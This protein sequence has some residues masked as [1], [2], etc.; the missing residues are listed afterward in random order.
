MQI[1]GKIN[2]DADYEYSGATATDHAECTKECSGNSPDQSMASLRLQ[3]GLKRSM[4]PSGLV[5]Q[6]RAGRAQRCG[7]RPGA[8]IFP[9]Q[10]Q[11]LFSR[12]DTFF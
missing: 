1:G 12:L 8:D 7:A 6:F 3:I 10:R 5:P 4:A 11:D 9:D 2:R